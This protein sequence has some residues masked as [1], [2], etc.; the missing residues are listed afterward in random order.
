MW[1]VF[2]YGTGKSNKIDFIGIK[3][4][5]PTPETLTFLVLY[6][7]GSLKSIDPDL[8]GQTLT[9]SLVFRYITRTQ[10]ILKKKARTPVF[11]ILM[12][13]GIE[14]L[15]ELQSLTFRERE[16][17]EASRPIVLSS[18]INQLLVSD[19]SETL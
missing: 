4:M 9:L 1:C 10:K 17:F 15:F 16:I 5:T 12:Y 8:A 13:Q 19:V 2:F 14:C 3:V 18:L 6:R 7:N 11:A